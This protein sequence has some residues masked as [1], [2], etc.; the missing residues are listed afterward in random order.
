MKY[1][2][3]IIVLEDRSRTI[4][5]RVPR[6]SKYVLLALLITIV[7]IFVFSLFTLRHSRTVSLKADSL[8]FLNDRLVERVNML[9][10]IEGD[11]LELKQLESTVRSILGDHTEI[12]SAAGWRS[13]S[14]RYFYTDMSWDE[15]F[16]RGSIRLDSLNVVMEKQ[17]IFGLPGL[18][19]QTI[20]WSQIPTI[21][22]TREGLVTTE[23]FQSSEDDKQHL[24]IDIAASEGSPVFCTANGT[25]TTVRFDD[26]LGNLI[27]IDHGANIVTRY[28]HNSKCFVSKGERVL[29]GQKISLIGSSGKSS[30][31]HLHY[32][33]VLGDTPLDPR[34]FFLE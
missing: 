31:P 9:K 25:V 30:A 18:F 7:A 23:F 3:I 32:E 1:Y 4:S 33:V 12:E 28:G 5:F 21:W 13:D 34:Q 11:F 6:Y 17:N 19:R 24:G 14:L 15:S 22:P 27:E 2:S 10:D 16:Q 8:E 29:K 20:T 26:Q